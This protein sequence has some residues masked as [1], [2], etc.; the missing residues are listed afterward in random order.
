M[1]ITIPVLLDSHCGRIAGRMG[2]HRAYYGCYRRL[3]VITSR[4]VSD[5]N[6]EEYHRLVEHFRPQG[7]HK[8]RVDPAQFDVDLQAEVAESLRRGFVHVFPL[9]ALSGH[10][11][12]RV[13][14]A[15]H[16]GCGV[17][18]GVS[19]KADSTWYSRW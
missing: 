11:E 19:R 4:W 15:L 8:D 1:S 9:H 12:D 16:F 17:R 2:V 14:D 6:S 10:P 3:L 7:R 18:R 5:I 13:A